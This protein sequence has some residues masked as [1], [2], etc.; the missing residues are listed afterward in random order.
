MKS[1]LARRVHFI[2]WVLIFS[3]FQFA[4]YFYFIFVLLIYGLVFYYFRQKRVDSKYES[5]ITQRVVAAPCSGTLTRVIPP[6]YYDEF[7]AEMSC[8]E[9]R[10]EPWKE[11]G[12]YSPYSAEVKDVKRKVGLAHFRF[13][14]DD[15]SDYSAI[16]LFLE[17]KQSTKIVVEFI[18]CTLGKL[19]SLKV[20]AGD[21][22]KRK[23][24]IGYFPF[25]GTVRVY[26]P[27]SVEVIIRL[28][29]EV[30]STETVLGGVEQLELKDE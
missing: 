22:V 14:K 6:R 18:E 27:Q 15:P 25:G 29:D 23:A 5:D 2:F 10:V 24:N 20:L 4:F 1:F 26:L 19:P 13:K 8:L 28:G 21:R 11:L 16:Q 7:E 3:L 17:D 30:I 12:I 9:I